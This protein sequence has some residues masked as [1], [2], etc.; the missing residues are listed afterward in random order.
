MIL[1]CGSSV[2][3]SW[4]SSPVVSCL[5]LVRMCFCYSN[6]EMNLLWC[7]NHNLS[8]I[9]CKV[10]ELLFLIWILFS[11]L[12]ICR[13]SCREQSPPAQGSPEICH[14]HKHQSWHHWH[15]DPQNPERRLLQEEEAEEAPSPGGRDLWHRERGELKLI[16][17]Y[18][19]WPL[20]SDLVLMCVISD[21]MDSFSCLAE[22]PADRAEES[23]SESCWYSAPAPYQESSPVEGIPALLLLSV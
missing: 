14:C 5:L 8:R 3:C 12:D 16:S 11:F 17:Q 21:S 22:V 7:R 18:I 1:V 2:W 23:R 10:T 6:L 4:S 15:E 20:G 19:F 13:P 9:R